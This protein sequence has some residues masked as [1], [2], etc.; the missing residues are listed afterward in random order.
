MQTLTFCY[1]FKSKHIETPAVHLGQVILQELTISSVNLRNVFTNLKV[2]LNID[3]LQYR[4]LGLSLTEG[5]SSQRASAPG[6]QLV[7]CS[8]TK[9]TRWLFRKYF[10]LYSLVLQEEASHFDLTGCT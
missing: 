5:R 6:Q 10:L 7:H 1:G 2:H 3:T 8:K 4:F 9:V